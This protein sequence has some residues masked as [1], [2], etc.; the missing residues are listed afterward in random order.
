MTV[1]F[2]EAAVIPLYEPFVSQYRRELD[3]AIA[4]GDLLQRTSE[5]FEAYA[6]K[7][8]EAEA[9]AVK[10][11]ERAKKAAEAEAKKL[12]NEAAEAAKKKAEA[13]AK[14]QGGGDA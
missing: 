13:E 12:A 14:K 2:D 4:N 5:E 11:A 1:Q 6:K 3:A 10:A 9:E 8:D 7:R